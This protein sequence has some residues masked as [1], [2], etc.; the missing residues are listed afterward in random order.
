MP[1]GNIY[2]PA[3]A[4]CACLERTPS[5]L[6]R[7]CI[8]GTYTFRFRVHATRV[9]FVFCFLR[10]SLFLTGSGYSGARPST[11]VAFSPFFWEKSVREHLLIVRILDLDPTVSVQFYLVRTSIVSVV[12][13]WLH[14]VPPSSL[15]VVEDPKT[16]YYSMLSVFAAF[17]AYHLLVFR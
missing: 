12:A 8:F 17:Q 7:A 4:V 9:L 11:V 15:T 6:Y 14:K 1:D 16:F 10:A 3:S 13:S 2:P 5:R